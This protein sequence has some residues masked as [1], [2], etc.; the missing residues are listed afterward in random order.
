MKLVR[1]GLTTLCIIT[2]LAI[3]SAYGQGRTVLRAHVPFPFEAGK[4]SIPAGNYQF[5]LN[6][7]RQSLEISGGQG[8]PV[9]LQF[10]T[11]LGGSS[12]FRD[13]G[14]VFD[15]Y[16]GKHVLSELWIPGQEGVLV[17]STSKEHQYARVI[18][19]VDNPGS[20]LS[21]KQVFEQTCER[22][23]GKNGAGNTAARKFFKANIPRLDSALVQGKSDAELR[24]I[25][26]NGMKN[27]P[28]VQIGQPRVQ[29]LLDSASVD[30]VIQYLRTLKKH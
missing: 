19:V 28:P 11:T 13:A 17:S 22:C 21:G 3:A 23:H 15:I 6:I 10:I 27:M 7:P 24:D 8:R 30:K 16:E 1:R 5:R 12:L 2:L 26:S 9:R 25:I 29:H 14:L 18:A 4:A 20:N